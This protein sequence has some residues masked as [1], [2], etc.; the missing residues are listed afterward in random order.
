[1]SA[2]GAAHCDPDN[3]KTGWDYQA[4]ISEAFIML[5]EG[6]LDAVNNQRAN[7]L[8]FDGIFFFT[9]IRRRSGKW[10]EGF[11]MVCVW[12]GFKAPS[13]TYTFTSSLKMALN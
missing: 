10:V 9:K 4:A 11:I 8:Y 1:M 6:Q 13:H 12:G 5:G 7:F 3:E 2:V